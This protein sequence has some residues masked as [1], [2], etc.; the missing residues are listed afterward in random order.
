[1][2]PIPAI[3][4]PTCK[5]IFN[6]TGFECVERRDN[7]GWRHGHYRNEVYRREA[8]STLWSVCYRVSTDGETNELRE[9]TAEISQVEAY[10]KTIT[11]YRPITV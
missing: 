8:D 7:A 3:V 5:E 6:E 2:N 4:P 10:Q 9:G 1:M 11:A